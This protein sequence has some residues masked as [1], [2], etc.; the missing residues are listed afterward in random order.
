MAEHVADP[1]ADRMPDDAT[2]PGAP[3]TDGRRSRGD[4]SRK[5]ITRRAVDLASLDGLDGLSFGRLADELSISKAG[6]QTLFR[7][8]ERLQLATID[9]ARTVFVDTVIRPAVTAPEGAERLWALIGNWIDYATAPLFPGGCFWTANLAEFDSRPGPVRDA[10]MEQHHAWLAALAHELRV[11][12]D[13]G[14][15]AAPEPEVTAFQLQAV[16]SAMNIALRWGDAD[17]V[18]RAHRALDTLLAPS[19]R[20]STSNTR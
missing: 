3:P 8:K 15:I 5:A 2:S 13:R 11:A 20:H 19:T 14:E 10:L 16:L 4:R 17:S 18:R 9:E 12:A 7:T 6:I 1:G